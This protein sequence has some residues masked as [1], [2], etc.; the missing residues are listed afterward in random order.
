[1]TMNEVERLIQQ[2][3]ELKLTIKLCEEDLRAH[4]VTLDEYRANG[5]LDHY[6]AKDGS[7]YVLNCRLLP[8]TTSRW[9]YSKAVK[10]LQEQEQLSG[11]ATRKE[12]TYL[13]F[14]QLKHAAAAQ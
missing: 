10:E 12:T 11:A 1:M 9:A 3:R 7:F 5:L 6:E 2:I 8:V 14:E 13:R 4:Q